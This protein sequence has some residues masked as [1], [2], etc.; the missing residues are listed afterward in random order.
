MADR[1]LPAVKPLKLRVAATLLCCLA[2]AVTAQQSPPAMTGAPKPQLRVT[3]IDVRKY[4]RV[5]ASFR[6]LGKTG[7]FVPSVQTGD[8]RVTVTGVNAKASGEPR[9]SLSTYSTHG[10][11]LASMLL[12]DQSGSMKRIIRECRQA[13][14]AYAAT[15]SSHDPVGL[16]TFGVRTQVHT[17]PTKDRAS[18]AKATEAIGPTTQNTAI[19]D[20]AWSCLTVLSQAPA[21]KRALV[22]LSDGRDNRSSHS[23]D[24]L[25]AAAHE[26]SILLCCVALGPRVDAS[27]LRRL[28]EGSGGVY[29]RA[30]TSD[31]LGGLYREIA[32]SLHNE[33]LIE[34]DLSAVTQPRNWYD[35]QLAVS[36][37]GAVVQTSHRFLTDPAPPVGAPSF[38]PR[39]GP[40]AAMVASLGCV[41]VVLVLCLGA[42]ARTR[43]R[44]V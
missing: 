8:V 3:A 28:A 15:L 18:F 9:F 14:S 35:L 5:T 30:N 12:V 22:I 37:G 44:P 11:T 21:N 25:I 7:Q 42:L 40:P 6:V 1:H 20:A 34:T 33:Y 19:V 24:E 26:K 41:L 10:L 13:A 2:Q 27:L 23:A 31:E 16:A 39:T 43:R 32:T 36:T 17:A 38:G 29:R 4:P